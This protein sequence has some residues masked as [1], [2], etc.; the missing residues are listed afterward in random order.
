MNF[1]LWQTLSNIG[2]TIGLILSALGGLGSYYFGKKSDNSK[3]VQLNSQIS[4]LV[5]GN[6][7][8]SQKLTPFEKMAERIYPA[9]EKR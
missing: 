5:Q 4:I 2:M 6:E 7:V 8:L 3:E 9:L 1:E